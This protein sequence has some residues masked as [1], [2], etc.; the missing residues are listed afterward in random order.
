V[1]RKLPMIFIVGLL[2]GGALGAL[3]TTIFSSAGLGPVISFLSKLFITIFFG[4]ALGNIMLG[5]VVGLLGG[6][7][8]IG[9]AT[10]V[11]RRARQ[12][13]SAAKQPPTYGVI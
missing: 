4:G 5:A 6:L 9:G 3:C 1:N 12:H 10:A 11:F 2:L 8:L 13:Q 7:L